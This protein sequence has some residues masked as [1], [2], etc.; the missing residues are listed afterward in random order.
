MAKS[1]CWWMNYY[2]PVNNDEI[3]LTSG[4]VVKSLDDR[5][6][7][8]E[9]VDLYPRIAHAAFGQDVEIWETKVYRSDPILCDGD[10]PI[11]KLRKWYDRFY[12]PV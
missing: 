1:Q 12:Q 10:G 3:D 6:L 4:V 2:T 7:P 5:P 9:F 8:Q 11:N